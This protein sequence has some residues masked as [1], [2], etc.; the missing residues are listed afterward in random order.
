MENPLIILGLLKS[1]EIYNSGKY[2]NKGAEEIFDNELNAY[3]KQNINELKKFAGIPEEAENVFYAGSFSI[4]RETSTY[5]EEIDYS[6]N[7][8][9]IK[10]FITDD[11]KAQIIKNAQ[12]PFISYLEDE[13]K[14][15]YFKE[16]ALYVKIYGYD[17]NL[18]NNVISILHEKLN[19]SHAS[20]FD[21]DIMKFLWFIY[22]MSNNEEFKN[23]FLE[24]K[25]DTLNRYKLVFNRYSTDRVSRYSYISNEIIHLCRFLAFSYKY[26]KFETEL[27]HASPKEY[28]NDNFKII[29][30]FIINFSKN[31]K[32]LYNVIIDSFSS[33]N[34]EDLKNY[35]FDNLKK[36][37]L[38]DTLLIQRMMR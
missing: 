16:F 5:T 13:F 23:L 25:N 26:E 6:I 9:T 12:A 1:D 21:E 19:M 32:Q 24:F 11:I 22:K 33:L 38:F 20:F 35:L 4:R 8:E 36:D 27:V 10:K 31:K 29:K 15:E 28:M 14:K 18:A 2:G 30:D 34:D 17:E 37:K 7:N 3:L